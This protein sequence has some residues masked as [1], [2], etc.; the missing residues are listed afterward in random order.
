MSNENLRSLLDAFPNQIPNLLEYQ[1]V[2]NQHDA[3]LAEAMRINVCISAE[4]IIR[5]FA[6]V[7]NAS[8]NLY[9]PQS[10]SNTDIDQI[11]LSYLEGLLPEI[12]LSHVRILASWPS[13]A[14]SKYNPAPKVR[15]TARRRVESLERELFPNPDAG[16]RFC[17]GVRLS[18]KQMACKKMSYNDGDYELTFSLKWLQKYTDSATILNNFLYVF[19]FVGKDGILNCASHGR[20]GSTLMKIMGLHSLEEYR[21]T[22]K[23]QAENKVIPGKILL[24]EKLLVENET[25]I[26]DAIEWFF[27]DYIENEFE[28]KGFSISLPTEETSLLDKCKAIG[29]EIERVLKAFMLYA[30]KGSIDTAYF[31][32][33]SIKTF[34]EIPS[35]LDRK[36]LIEG[37]EYEY[38]A[39]LLLSDQSRLAYLPTHPKD[40]GEFYR[41]LAHLHLTKD[42]FYEVYHPQ[43]DYLIERGFVETKDNSVLHLTLRAHL[44]ALVWKRGAARL[45]DSACFSEQIEKLVSE[46]V[47]AYSNSLFSPDEAD[48]LSC[49]LNNA[50][51]SNTWALRNKY[52]HGSGSVS[53]FSE[54]EL[55]YDYSL[56]LSA[57]IGLVLKINEELSNITGKGGIDAT[58]L[59]DW[60]LTEE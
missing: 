30:Q 42:D 51:F 13:S 7:S 1:Q 36:Y 49:L 18:E 35:L 55:K 39:T 19:D 57:L 40:S 8:R 45:N 59:V 29:P 48:Y 22:L 16:I 27:N 12:N 17:L 50:K 32:Y 25:R 52:D 53:D 20:T 37:E 46:K 15:V 14:N 9:L 23:A 21:M 4:A 24:Y 6:V 10:L 33:I 54:N 34:R 11:M 47:L 3:A 28:I 31:P 41:L 5:A 43:L 2:V 38:P 60:P 44:I 58:G 26:E 56:M